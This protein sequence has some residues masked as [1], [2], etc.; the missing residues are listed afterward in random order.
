VSAKLYSLVLSHPSQAARLMLERKGIE[1]EVKDLFPGAHPAQLRLAGFRGGTVPALKLDGQRVQG[2]LQI[3]RALDA[4][5]AEPRLFPADPEARR[6]VEE[7]EAWGERELQPVPRRM[8]RWGA[9]RRQSMRV[10]MARDMGMPAPSLLAAVQKPLAH[11]FARAVGVSGERTRADVASVPG[12]L[13]RVDAL[14]AA[15]VIGGDEPNAADFQIGTTIRVFLAYED[16]RGLVE[17][18]PAA[19]LAMRL[20]PRYPGPIPPFLPREWLAQIA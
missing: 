16:L 1:H 18:R 8:F 20:L 11:G 6:A 17:G 7:A 2:S 9:S 14:I 13:D 10:W 12:L 5:R 3:S 19:A 15:G 4:A